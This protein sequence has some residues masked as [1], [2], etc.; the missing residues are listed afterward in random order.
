MWL[1]LILYHSITLNIKILEDK[2]SI[3][4]I[5]ESALDTDMT[6]SYRQWKL[7]NIKKKKSKQYRLR[8]WEDGR[9]SWSHLWP[10]FFHEV[11]LEQEQT[12]W[13]RSIW[14][15][16]FPWDLL[17]REPG[18]EYTFLCEERTM[19]RMVG[20]ARFFFLAPVIKL[21]TVCLPCRCYAA[22]LYPLP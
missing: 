17:G 9:N 8:F 15:P 14:N 10:I 20:E 16:K 12:C 22:E 11:T 2:V 6:I 1:L 4:L 21:R 18:G 5:H 19:A 7:W 13:G 3:L